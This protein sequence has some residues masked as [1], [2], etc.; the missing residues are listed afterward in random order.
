MDNFNNKNE[1]DNNNE[2]NIENY[3][4]DLSNY[5]K[6]H[7]KTINFYKKEVI[8]KYNDYQHNKEEIDKLV[9]EMKNNKL[10]EFNGNENVFLDQ[11]KEN[12]ECL[13][14]AVLFGEKDNKIFVSFQ[15][16]CFGRKSQINVNSQIKFISKKK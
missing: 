15:T 8:E 6:A 16:K 7:L 12:G 5:I 13:D 3:K 4:D 2:S 14:Y 1:S 9:K 10:R 11:Q